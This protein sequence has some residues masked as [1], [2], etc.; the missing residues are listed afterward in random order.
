LLPARKAHPEAAM[1]GGRLAAFARHLR[2][3]GLA[4]LFLIGFLMMGGFTTVYNYAGFR[5]MA[6]P[7]RLS[8]G[9]V[10]LIFVVYLLGSVASAAAGALA[11]RIGRGPVLIAG[12]A[13]AGVG[14]AVTLMPSLIGIVG[15]IALVTMGFFAAHSIASGW[16]GG[17]ARG[18]K[19]QASALYLLAY[20]LGASII[21]SLGGRAWTQGGWPAI[22]AMVGGLLALALVAALRVRR[23]AAAWELAPD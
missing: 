12:I 6:A 10:G 20:Y 11:D 21:G 3:P 19:G 23:L 22:A 18:A 7:Y 4:W 8:Q 1:S 14:A 9:T 15:G 16:V 17:V 5:L 13:I 2:T